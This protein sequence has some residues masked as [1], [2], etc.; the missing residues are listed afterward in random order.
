MN[1]LENILFFLALVVAVIGVFVAY[2]LIKGE[3]TITEWSEREISN[4][5]QIL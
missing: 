4:I 3:I 5:Y 2:V 1:L